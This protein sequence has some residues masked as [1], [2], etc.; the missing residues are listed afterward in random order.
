MPF[1]TL[2]DDLHETAFREDADMF[3]YRRLTDVEVLGNSGEGQR[4]TG[5]QT[6][7]GAAGRICDRLKYIPSCL[8]WRTF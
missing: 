2:F 6:D 5:Q 4:L 1:P 8:H 7:H 3:G